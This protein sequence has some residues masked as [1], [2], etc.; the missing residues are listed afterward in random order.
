MSVYTDG[1][2]PLWMAAR[3]L[4]SERGEDF[5]RRREKALKSAD[6]EDIHDLRVASRRLREGLALFAPCYPA[7]NIARLMRQLKRV[8][9]LLGEIRNTDEA[10][11]FFAVLAEEL[12]PEHGVEL[13]GILGPYGSKRKKELKRLRSGL[14]EIAAD[15]LRA[16]CRRVI[17]APSL[18]TPQANGIDLFMPLSQFAASALD[19]RLAAVLQL[20]PEARQATETEAQHLLRIAIK[21]F[22]YRLEIL[23]FLFTSH[24]DE[25]HGTLKDYQD[26]L[27]KMHDLDVFAG[28]VH[29]AGFLPPV[30]E[31][32]QDA[33]AAKRDR[34]FADFSALLEIRPLEKLGERMRSAL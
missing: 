31:F 26:L 27:G 25:I 14:K 33:M 20:L 21:H 34:L 30:E 8:T 7:G 18:F 23:S 17:N 22:R 16:L 1:T 32:I 15:S 10:I 13:D 9:R 12:P 11:L 2:T 28:I 4:L 24:Y 3:T 6:A 29:E 5:F 19:A